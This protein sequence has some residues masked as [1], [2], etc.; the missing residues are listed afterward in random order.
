MLLYVIYRD[1]FVDA[2]HQHD[3]RCHITV[4]TVDVLNTEFVQEA[5]YTV[6]QRV[7]ANRVQVR[8]LAGVLIRSGGEN[9]EEVH[10][11]NERKPADAQHGPKNEV[12]KGQLDQRLR[13]VL[14]QL[15][16]H[17]AILE[18]RIVCKLKC[19]DH[20]VIEDAPEEVDEELRLVHRDMHVIIRQIVHRNALREYDCI[21]E[22]LRNRDRQVEAEA[23]QALEEQFAAQLLKA[24]CLQPYRLLLQGRHAHTSFPNLPDHNPGDD[25]RQNDQHTREW[26]EGQLHNV[27]CLRLIFL[28]FEEEAVYERF[29]AE[30]E[31]LRY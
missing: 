7:D 17:L 15:D 28:A 22:H 25:T 30:T 8:R 3:N 21:V 26:G 19:A 29:E 16:L 24:I 9:V 14:R 12:A 4:A 27:A 5:H 11:L 10:K 23:A 20:A 18:Q 2:A 31:E 1:E 13:L 6:N